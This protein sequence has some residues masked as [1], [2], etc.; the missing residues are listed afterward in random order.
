MAFGL[1]KF[2]QLSKVDE[3][4]HE[5]WGIASSEAPDADGE[6]A[7]YDATK[8]A[9][10]KWSEDTLNKTQ[11]AGQ[12]PSLGNV[13]LQHTLT[14]AGKVI[15]IQYDD[16]GRK[17]LIGSQPVN[18]EI[19]E[20][21]KGGFVTGYSMGGGYA[22]KKP[23]GKYT[24][25]APVLAEMSYV[26]AACNPEA[27]FTYI[28]A[29]GNSELRKFKKGDELPAG[30]LETMAKRV[31]AILQKQANPAKFLH[32]CNENCFHVEDSELAKETK[33]KGGQELHASEFAFVG[34]AD[35]P[36]T[37]KL[38]IHD[39]AHVRN[40]LARFNQTEGIPAGEKD[41]VHARIV[42]AAKKFGVE[43]SEKAL[44][45][46]FKKCE[47]EPTGKVTRF[48]LQ[49][50]NGLHKGLW[51]VA[52]MAELLDSLYGL[53]MSTQYEAEIEQDS[54]SIPAELRAHL[55]SLASTL[56]SLAEEETEE[57]ISAT[58]GKEKLLMAL[59]LND[60]QKAELQKARHSIDQMLD[61]LHKSSHAMHDGMIAHHQ[62]MQECHKAHCAKMIGMHD[63]AIAQH[64]D[65][66]E[67]VTDHI[68]KMKKALGVM[69]G[70]TE[71]IMDGHEADKAAKDAMEK[72]AK[73]KTDKEAADRAAAESAM[74]IETE[75]M[76]K[77]FKEQ[78]EKFEKAQQETANQIKTLVEQVEK[79][80][81]AAATTIVTPGSQT[82]PKLITPEG[83]HLQKSSAD[84]MRDTGI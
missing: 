42:A 57:I 38:P 71:G 76:E 35:D 47:T 5:V 69:G 66:K 84:T 34:D 29:D 51:Q 37:W 75:K 25:F 53:C 26:D 60:M 33:K 43:V 8:A 16:E 78:Q 39:A 82:D 31:A 20:L 32:A 12:D 58:G 68:A 1:N 7:D 11:A 10:Q 70:E 62:T 4:T 18:D 83:Q 23:D 65:R 6:I 15:K 19:W 45:A 72:A 44:R 30:V 2:I 9:F 49:S 27:N 61:N 54:S 55:K 36:S 48:L 77:A 81:K 59:E 46:V 64:Q 40:A 67:E 50:V 21:V 3:A 13:R 56:I 74:K 17:V 79:L 24:R 14:I 80:T 41:K 52:Q 63:K 22:W 28:K 73:E